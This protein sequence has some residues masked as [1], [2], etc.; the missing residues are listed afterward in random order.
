MTDIELLFMVLALVYGWECTC[1]V[2]RGSVLFVTWFGA[3]WRIRN[4]G[5][6]LGSAASALPIVASSLYAGIWMTS[7]IGAFGRKF[8]PGTSHRTGTG[9]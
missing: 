4:P 2:R 5:T 8:Q 3:R 7:F 9:I 1:W 6:L